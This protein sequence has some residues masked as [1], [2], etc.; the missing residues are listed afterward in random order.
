MSTNWADFCSF[1]AAGINVLCGVGILTTP[2]ALKEGGWLS[3]CLFFVLAVMSF[4]TGILLR[5]C[6][7]S[8]PGLVTYPDIGQAAFGITGRVIISVRIDNQHVLLF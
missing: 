1:L 8:Q 4:Y 6:L 7:D 2:Y 5:R 3:L